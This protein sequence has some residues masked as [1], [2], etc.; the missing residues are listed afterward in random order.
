MVL[1][2]ESSI[3]VFIFYFFRWVNFKSLPSIFLF[4]PFP[5][6]KVSQIFSYRL[7]NFQFQSFNIFWST[8]CLLRSSLFKELDLSGCFLGGLFWACPIFYRTFQ[9]PFSWVIC[10]LFKAI[11]SLYL[12][13]GLYPILHGSSA[14]FI[15]VFL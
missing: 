1:F 3:N 15:R 6:T 11:F 12:L 9:W 2:L 10:T 14:S 5:L 7:V 13:I 8:V 4:L